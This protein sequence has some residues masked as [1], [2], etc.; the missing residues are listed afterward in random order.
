[1]VLFTLQT[2]SDPR[3]CV[4]ASG[5]MEAEPSTPS[6][7]PP[8]RSAR[9]TRDQGP[10]SPSHE[11]LRASTRPQQ[12]LIRQAPP[13]RPDF[14]G[15][16]IN[17]NSSSSVATAVTQHHQALQAAARARAHVTILIASAIDNCI[18]SCSS[19]EQKKVALELQQRVIQALTS[20]STSSSPTSS[21]ASTSRDS[22]SDRSAGSRPNGRVTYADAARAPQQRDNNATTRSAQSQ[23]RSRSQSR[24]RPN[25]NPNPNT[26][27]AR[28]QK[29]D[30]RIFISV[31]AWTRLQK[32]S[33]FAIR[34]AIVDSIQGLT[35]QDIPVASAIKTGWAITPASKA[36]RDELMT[37][38]NRKLMM[39]AVDGDSI[40]LP[41]QWINY[42]VQG[43]DSAYRTLGGESI[44]TTKEMVAEEALSQTGQ[45]PVDCRISRHGASANGLT[46]W[47]ISYRQPVRSFRLFGTSDFAKE[48]RKHPAVQRHEDGCQGYCNS[49]RCTRAVRCINCSERK[50]GHEGPFGDL[51]T[52]DHKCANCYGPHRAGHQDCPA[53][54][55]RVSGKLIKPTKR[56]LVAIRKIGLQ[57]TQRLQAELQR[58]LNEA[59]A[60]TEPE[61]NS[62]H[63]AAAAPRATLTTT[64][65]QP[66]NPARRVADSNAAAPAPAPST[67]NSRP[68]RSQ[69]GRVNLNLMELSANSFRQ[70]G[71][72]DPSA[73]EDVAMDDEGSPE[74]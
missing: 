14:G 18:A 39:R 30:P 7:L 20:S 67:S 13:Q 74:L 2:P 31:P 32:P 50:D 27:R 61:N 69:T 68:R 29:E 60:P 58:R 70:R 43:V 44:P 17:G 11:N 54:P 66:P 25:T 15:V 46:T 12:G 52:R 34:K 9:R 53:I 35:L 1:M 33:P 37:Q 64:R 23:Q 19:P 22:S 40:R 63:Q 26:A 3:C 21:D 48:I 65:P 62:G 10:E 42:A 59:Q 6:R 4:M 45:T 51:C 56:E 36:V 41:E 8:D 38:E 47:I 28:L 57:A 72:T 55:K 71:H 5:A 73:S 16:A 24:P 49:S